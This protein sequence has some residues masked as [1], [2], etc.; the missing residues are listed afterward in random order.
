MNL[1]FLAF[2]PMQVV[3]VYNCLYIFLKSLLFILFRWFLCE[4]KLGKYLYLR[5]VYKTI[6]EAHPTFPLTADT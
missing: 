4:N 3:S 1:S 2:I 6:N 5:S